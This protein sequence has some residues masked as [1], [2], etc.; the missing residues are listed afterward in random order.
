MSFYVIIIIIIIIVRYRLY[1]FYV[2]QCLW[3]QVTAGAP[4][5]MPQ[6]NAFSHEQRVP[7]I[8]AVLTTV[9]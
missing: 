8:F 3:C 7:S 2:S 4:V 1:T 9:T 6:L 5:S